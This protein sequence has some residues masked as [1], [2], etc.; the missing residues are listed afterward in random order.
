MGNYTEQMENELFDQFYKFDDYDE[1]YSVLINM[2]NGENDFRSFGEGLLF[3]LQKK[4]PSLNK[5]NVIKFIEEKCVAND[6]P[7]N[8][9]ASLN[10]LKNWFKNDLRPKK[11]EE[12]R[13]SIFALA[14]A[15][16]FGVKETAELFHKVYL[17]RA[18]DFRNEK[19][20]FR[21]FNSNCNKF[22]II[23]FNYC[24]AYKTRNKCQ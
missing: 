23:C 14:F 16:Q 12:S 9:V 22:T 7:K 1:D 19:E 24:F 8:E 21:N 10:T 15:L 20:D 3:Y 2:L 13:K 4:D 6:V 5:E 17:D 18:F 11:S